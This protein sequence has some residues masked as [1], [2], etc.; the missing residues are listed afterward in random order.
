M[1]IVKIK[2]PQEE[3]DVVWIFDHSPCHT[4]KADDAL[5]V[6]VMGAKDGGKQPILRDTEFIN[7]AGGV[8]KQRMYVKQGR[9]KIP[10]GLRTVL[11][12]RGHNIAGFKKAEF[13]ALLA[14]EPDFIREASIVETYLK[15]QGYEAQFFPKFHCEL[16]ATEP[17]WCQSK[18]HTRAYCKYSIVGLRKQVRPALDSVT[19]DLI[20]K[21]FR[22][23]KDFERAYR[24]GHVPGTG[25]TNQIKLYKSHRRVSTAKLT[26]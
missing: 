15:S 24:E 9:K 25:M 26:Q 14:A 2:Y 10:K 19:V 18:I 17:C 7:A 1:K 11:S 13:V 8:I 20:R 22:K 23:V 6:S 4:K 12:E 21:F 5:C 3:H 16:N